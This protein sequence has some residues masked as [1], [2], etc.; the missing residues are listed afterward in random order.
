MNAQDAFT[1]LKALIDQACDQCSFGIA[2]RDAEALGMVGGKGNNQWSL[3]YDFE[4]VDGSGE[5]V[6]L[7]FHSYDQSKAY[8]VCPGMNK[9]ELTLTAITGVTAVHRNQY[10]G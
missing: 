9:F 7:N 2:I 1:K 6:I 10:E 5:K 3:D 4:L 8:S